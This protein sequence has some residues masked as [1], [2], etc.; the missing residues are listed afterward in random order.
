MKKCYGSYTCLGP[1]NSMAYTVTYVT[2]KMREH[3]EF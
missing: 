3:R 1:V 2:G